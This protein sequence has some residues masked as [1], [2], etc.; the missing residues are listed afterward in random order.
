[1][2]AAHGIRSPS[3]ALLRFLR[4]QLDVQTT[5]YASPARR[6]ASRVNTSSS[7]QCRHASTISA[8][9][10]RAET[11]SARPQHRPTS[12]ERHSPRRPT[13][14]TSSRRAS[15]WDRLRAGSAQPQSGRNRQDELAPLPGFLDDSAGLSGRIIKPSNEL[16]LR[17]TEVD[18]NGNVVLV[19]GEFRK[20]ELIAKVDTRAFEDWS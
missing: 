3:I 17:C 16:K 4:C 18:E 13:F 1:M 9:L 15:I 10:T 6:I 5:A 2:K 7:R 12:H 19:N 8:P 11:A 14:C 20:S